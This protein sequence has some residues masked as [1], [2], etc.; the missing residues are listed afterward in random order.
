LKLSR[1][2][3]FAVVCLAIALFIFAVDLS[4]ILSQSLVVIPIYHTG[5]LYFLWSDYVELT[6]PV[7]C[8]WLGLSYGFW[9]GSPV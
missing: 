4:E 2:S 8:V 1:P 9:R 3:K 7:G 5:T 6:F